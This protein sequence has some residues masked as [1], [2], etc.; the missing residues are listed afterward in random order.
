MTINQTAFEELLG[1]AVGDLAAG[2]SGFMINLGGKLGLYRAM[3][4]AGPQSSAEVARRAGCT[5]RYVRE[6]LHDQVAGGYVQYHAASQT[7][8]LSPD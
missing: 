6:W 3:A 4:G 2:A 8:E 7:F 5:E 1:R